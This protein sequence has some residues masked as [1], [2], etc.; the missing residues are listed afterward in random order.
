MDH[1]EVRRSTTRAV[2]CVAFI[3]KLLYEKL[4]LKCILAGPKWIFKL[5]AQLK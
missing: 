4:H 5:A 1:S 2:N 3:V